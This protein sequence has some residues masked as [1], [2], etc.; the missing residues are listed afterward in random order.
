MA[1]R[2]PTEEELKT[3]INQHLDAMP[4]SDGVAIAWLSYLFGLLEWGLLDS[5]AYMRLVK[6]LPPGVGVKETEIMMLG[7][8]D[9]E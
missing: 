1:V 3:R 6:L 2:Y 5:H 8:T 9:E 4:G 7:I